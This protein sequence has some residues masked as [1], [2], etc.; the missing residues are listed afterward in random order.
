MIIVIKNESNLQ[1]K[2]E[3]IRLSKENKIIITKIYYI[4][5]PQTTISQELKDILNE[6]CDITRIFILLTGL[7]TSLEIAKHTNQIRPVAFDEYAFISSNYDEF[8][9]SIEEQNG[10]SNQI[11][12]ITIDDSILGALFL[13][14][15]SPAI[16]SNF[17]KF[18]EQVF[19]ETQKLLNASRISN[20]HN[21]YSALIYDSIYLY[22]SGL[23]KLL[24]KHQNSSVNDG[25]KLI[26]Q[27]LN[28]NYESILGHR[29]YIDLNG[30]ANGNYV[31]LTINISNKYEASSFRNQPYFENMKQRG[32][33]RMNNDF[34]TPELV[35]KEDS[36]DWLTNKKRIEEEPMCG[37][38]NDAC[39]LGFNYYLAIFFFV[40]TFFICLFI[41]TFFLIK[42]LSEYK[43]LETQHWKINYDD[44]TILDI[45][46]NQEDAC[47]V[48]KAIAKFKSDESNLFA[49]KKQEI[50]KKKILK[51]TDAIG[52]FKGNT[53]FIKKLKNNILDL[54]KLFCKEMMRV[55]LFF[56]FNLI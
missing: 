20:H 19:V 36:I 4:E 51:D 45:D 37:F 3:I 52:F 55:S 12:N 11:R 16:N 35:I 1:I 54:E 56:F 18:C 22:A 6:S 21:V 34:E 47:E 40:V 24:L 39:F 30:D 8:Y 10:Y 28:F 38:K 44:L 53:V 25:V 43:I 27:I 32:L 9:S 14:A 7:L 46:K 31:M 50:S 26:G 2:D 15:P 49:L 48:T 33:F 41:C 5:S 29:E 23:S 13:I 42:C 17:D